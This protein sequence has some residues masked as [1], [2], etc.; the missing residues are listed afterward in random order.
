VT[1]GARAPYRETVRRPLAAAF[2]LAVV[3]LTAAYASGASQIDQV[4]GGYVQVVA[5]A[6]GQVRICPDYAVAAAARSAPPPYCRAGLPAAGIQVA[7]LPNQ[8]S[9][10]AERWG[11]L[12]LAG[13]YQ[14]GTFQVAS[15]SQQ[16]PTGSTGDALARPPCRRPHGGWRYVAPTESQRH[17]LSTY[18][19][20]H[21]GDLV[22]IAFFHHGAILTVA[23]THPPRVRAL[24]GPAWPRQLCVV[25][26]R[27]SRPLVNQVRA[28]V[29]RLITVRPESRYGW[30]SGAGGDGVTSR[31]QPTVSLD[32]LIETGQLAAFLRRQPRGLVVV[33]ATLHPVAA[34][35]A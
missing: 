2:A 17:S 21:R 26:A 14:S 25:R 28:R 24:L 7:A 18:Q 5:Y 3:G 10:P 33:D 32:V 13:S 22:A 19:R 15:Q 34:G 1:G 8:S 16:A 12:Y 29:L 11:F 27:Y 31:G 35:Q 6:D 30:I 23:S 20:R 9:N 4:L